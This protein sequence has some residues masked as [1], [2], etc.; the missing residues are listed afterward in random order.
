M[1]TDFEQELAAYLNTHLAAP[2]A[3]HVAVSDGSAKTHADQPQIV[4]AVTTS[5]PQP[6][7]MGKKRG[8]VL[9][10]STDMRRVLRLICSAEITVIASDTG[11]RQQELAA[12]EQIHYLLDKPDLRNGVELVKSGDQGFIIHAARVTA[13]SHPSLST[14]ESAPSL[15]LEVRGWFWPVD[16]AGVTGVPIGTV[17]VRGVSHTFTVEPAAPVMQAGGTA[18]QFTIGMQAIGT[19]HLSGD[20]VSSTAFGALYCGLRRED[21][22]APGGTLGGGDTAIDGI[23]RIIQLVDGSLS[24]SYTPATSP[25][26]EILVIA[27]ENGMNGE[28]VELGRVPLVVASAE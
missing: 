22:T 6:D 10:G 4:I 16:I 18:Q 1:I 20:P 26:R 28:G 25:C 11:N 24:V 8:E 5:Q 14:T 9:P 19:M 15:T 7:D 13:T 12:I 17:R 21:G 27:F 23:G 2:F 3:G